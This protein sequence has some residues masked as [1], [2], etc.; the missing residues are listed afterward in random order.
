MAGWQSRQDLRDRRNAR[1]GPAIAPRPRRWRLSRAS[2]PFR[3]VAPETSPSDAK[4]PRFDLVWVYQ[5]SPSFEPGGE[6]KR[7]ECAGC[8]GG[9]AVRRLSRPA[10][11][12]PPICRGRRSPPSSCGRSNGW[13]S[14]RCRPTR[15]VGG[16]V[17]H[18]V[19][20]QG[21]TRAWPTCGSCLHRGRREARPLTTQDSND[22]NPAWSPTGK[23]IAFGEQARR[24]REPPGLRDR[25]R[26]RGRRGGSRR[27]RRAPVRSSGLLTRS[28]APGVREP[29]VLDLASWD[30]Q[31][32][33]LKE[34]KDSGGHRAGLDRAGMRYWGPL[35]RRARGRTS[36]RD[37]AG[38][39]R[40]HRGHAGHGPA[41]FAGRGRG[42]SYDISPDGKEIA[43]AA[44]TD[45]TG[46]DSN[47]DV[48]SWCPR[49]A[50]PRAT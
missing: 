36:T 45:A 13:P 11:R 21:R 8:C 40:H 35:A 30:E 43:F 9:R 50:A 42:P 34:R 6:G 24:R 33:R 23:W 37:P 28:R 25:D 32:E 27:C 14:R 12:R 7:E 41:V 44:D 19:P 26:G 5:P 10:A 29:R 49:P 16:A 20:G 39:W 17:G 46:V 2:E 48:L 18:G 4:V 31:G 22:T 47:F 15:Q 1:A 3:P 38:R